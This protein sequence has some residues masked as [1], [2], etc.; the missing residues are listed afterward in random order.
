MKATFFCDTRWRKPKIHI[1]MAICLFPLLILSVTACSTPA[2]LVT[3]TNTQE[4]IPTIPPTP[5]ATLIPVI[6]PGQELAP[7]IVGRTPEGGLSV[8]LNG[9]VELVFDVAMDQST[10]GQA[11][12]VSPS[13]ELGKSGTPILGQVVWMDNRHMKFSPAEPFKAG[14]RYVVSL[15]EQAKSLKGKGI[16]EAYHFSF[17]TGF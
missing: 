14:T 13:D 1:L 7:A 9:P 11:F 2:P 16:K 6:D 17:S 12:V 15:S 10:V 8:G 4:V 3:P 5:A